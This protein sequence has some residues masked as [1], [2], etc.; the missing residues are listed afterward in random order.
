MPYFKSGNLLF[1]HVPKTGGSSLELYFARKYSTSLNHSS[2]FMGLPGNITVNQSFDQGVALQHQTYRAI[3]ENQQALGIQIN[4]RTKIIT[5][6]RNPYQ[7]IISDLFYYKL[8][9]GSASPEEVYQIISRYTGGQYG[10]LDNHP[11]AQY[12]FLINHSGELLKNLIVMRTESLS[13]DMR[14]HG[15]MDFNIF[16]NI[17]TNRDQDYMN[18]LSED[19]INLINVVYEKDF[20]LFG[21]QMISC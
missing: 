7:R 17:G 20:I 13:D 12:K 9:T 5:I 8:I 15:Y 10:K 6:V 18:Y 11:L 19:S 2:L 4:E 3:H 14:S 16:A 1:L 21:Y